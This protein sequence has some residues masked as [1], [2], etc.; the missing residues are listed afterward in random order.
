MPFKS[1]V[2]ALA[3]DT[4]STI[5]PALNAESN[6]IDVPVVAVK[7]FPFTNLAPFTNT[8]TLPTSY[9]SDVP[10]ESLPLN[11]VVSVPNV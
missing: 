4:T 9:V 1:V 11:V 6:T 7:S 8:S 2:V 10:D 5:L 3:C